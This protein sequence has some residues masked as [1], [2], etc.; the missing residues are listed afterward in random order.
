M[1]VDKGEPIEYTYY[2][3]EDRRT[4]VVIPRHQFNNRF[5]AY[6][7]RSY[8]LN[9][10][11]RD[12]PKNVLNRPFRF[13]E[14]AVLSAYANVKSCFTNLENGNVTHFSLPWMRKKSESWCIPFPKEAFKVINDTRFTLFTR[15]FPKDGYIK[16]KEK[17]S[18]PNHDIKILFNGL[19]YYLIMP[20][21]RQVKVKQER[22]LVCALDPN[23]T[24]FYSLYDPNEY[25]YLIGEGTSNQIEQ[26]NFQIDH[27]NS[28]KTGD[29][30]E[31]KKIAKVK[32]M[33]RIRIANL[34]R[35]L[36]HK[37]SHFLCNNYQNIILPKDFGKGKLLQGENKTVKRRMISLKHCS[38]RDLLIAKAATSGT[39]IIFQEESY[40]SQRCG[41]CHTLTKTDSKEFVCGNSNC[42]LVIHRDLN[43]ARNILL[44]NMSVW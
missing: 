16:T 24:N 42:S 13:N 3:P 5:S 17:I 11:N 37:V 10:K 7:V 40:T 43:S 35:E 4:R 23:V 38:F 1:N 8:L 2:D 33:Y 20:Y 6:D 27:L 22:K 15:S 26:L 41:K 18:K 36:H 44:K 25:S 19:H 28:I 32:Q 29:T 39:N 21:Q 12:L 14:R 34:I 9:K 30:R 31:Q